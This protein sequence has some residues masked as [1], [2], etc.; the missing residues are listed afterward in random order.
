MKILRLEAEFPHE[1]LEDKIREAS[2]EWHDWDRDDLRLELV[3]EGTQGIVEIVRT[4]TFDVYD[5]IHQV[6][7]DWFEGSGMRAPFDPY[8]TPVRYEERGG[9]IFVSYRADLEPT[10]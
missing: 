10:R 4:A 9:A 8:T 5:V 1:W 3:A 7:M 6:V 2:E